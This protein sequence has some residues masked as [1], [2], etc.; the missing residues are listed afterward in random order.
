MGIARKELKN[1]S[2]K[3]I[4]TGNKLAAVND[5]HKPATSESA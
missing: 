1:E 2:F 5:R 4:A 3:G